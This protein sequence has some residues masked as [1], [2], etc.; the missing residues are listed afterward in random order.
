MKSGKVV[1]QSDCTSLFS[2]PKEEYT[3]NL[4]EAA[5]FYS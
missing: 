3:K 4:L 5:Y 1:E 2:N